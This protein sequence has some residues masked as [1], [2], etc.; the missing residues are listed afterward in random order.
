MGRTTPKCKVKS[1]NYGCSADH[2]ESNDRRIVGP[3]TVHKYCCIGVRATRP[4][5]TTN[6]ELRGINLTREEEV[7]KAFGA[8]LCLPTIWAHQERVS[9]PTKSF[10]SMVSAADT[11]AT[12]SNVTTGHRRRSVSTTLL[13]VTSRIRFTIAPAATSTTR[14]SAHVTLPKGDHRWHN[15]K[16]VLKCLCTNPNK[17]WKINSYDNEWPYFFGL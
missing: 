15:H 2:G 11:Y 3:T 12:V 14:L 17:F 16:K 9:K 13:F 1:A 6:R 10:N 7:E 5:A 4:N 8:T